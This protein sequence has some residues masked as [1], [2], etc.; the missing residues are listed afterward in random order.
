MRL[1]HIDMEKCKLSAKSAVYLIGLNL[2]HFF[3][4]CQLHIGHL[5]S[6]FDSVKDV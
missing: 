2:H 5:K 3:L 4:A 1:S 6:K